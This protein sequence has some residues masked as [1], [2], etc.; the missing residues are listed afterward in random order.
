MR[1]ILF[2]GKRKD[3][4]ELV[5]GYL[6][7]RNDGQYEISFYS[8]YFDSERFT[9][10]VIPETVGQ[11]IGLTDKN[12]KKIFEG[13]IIERLWLGEKHIYRIH[14]DSDIASFIGADIYSEGFTTFDYDACEFEV[15]GNIYDNPEFLLNYNK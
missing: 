10:D 15:I 3:N 1:E 12:G 7:I 8:K 13:D 14:Y 4:G 2:R 9:Y 11:Y 6:Y 5:Y